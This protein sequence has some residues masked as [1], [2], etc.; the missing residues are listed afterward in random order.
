MRQNSVLDAEQLLPAVWLKMLPMLEKM[1][2]GQLQPKAVQGATSVSSVELSEILRG[3]LK[4]QPMGEFEVLIA[5]DHYRDKLDSLNSGIRQKPD[6]IARSE[7]WQHPIPY[8]QLILG[9]QPGLTLVLCFNPS[10]RAAKG[11]R[12]SI[13]SLGSDT[14]RSVQSNVSTCQSLPRCCAIRRRRRWN[15]ITCNFWIAIRKPRVAPGK[16]GW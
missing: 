4:N 5:D 12:V 15:L 7:P 1:I 8:G 14:G 6:L 3:L 11:T 9:R 10:E 13:L 2:A 16:T